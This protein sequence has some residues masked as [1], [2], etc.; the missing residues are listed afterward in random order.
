MAK[1]VVPDEPQHSTSDRAE[2]AV[3]RD[4]TL[5]HRVDENLVTPAHRFPSMFYGNG[6]RGHYFHVLRDGGGRLAPM[7]YLSPEEE[8]VRRSDNLG[9]APL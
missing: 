1:F 6:V 4:E 3:I 9:S 7:Y 2:T 8:Q 5:A